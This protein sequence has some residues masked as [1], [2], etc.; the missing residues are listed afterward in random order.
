MPRRRVLPLQPRQQCLLLIVP[1]PR[2]SFFRSNSPLASALVSVDTE[3]V[4]ALGGGWG[5][6]EEELQ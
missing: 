2:S 3:K 1:E 5:L 4:S 6:L